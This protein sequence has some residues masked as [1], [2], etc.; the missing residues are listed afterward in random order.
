VWNIFFEVLGVRYTIEVN[1]GIGVE[2]WS[3][4]KESYPLI[5]T[6]EEVAHILGISKRKAYEVMEY[7]DFPLIRLGRVKRVGRE[8]FFIWLERESLTQQDEEMSW[9]KRK[10]TC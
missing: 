6:V 2:G 4:T 9:G 8:A 5:L 7:K 10:R 3:M 1:N